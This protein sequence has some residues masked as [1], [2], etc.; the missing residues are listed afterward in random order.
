M[1]E[2][3][4]VQHNVR[5]EM[6]RAINEGGDLRSIRARVRQYLVPDKV[7]KEQPP[8]P[9]ERRFAKLAFDTLQSADRTINN[10]YA[11]ALDL[12]AATWT[13]GLIETSRC[14]CQKLNGKTWTREELEAIDKTDWDGKSGSIFITAGGHQCRHI[15]RWLGVAATLRKRPDL[16]LTDRKLTQRIGVEPQAFNKC[17]PKEKAKAT[18]NR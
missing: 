15:P 13:G 10:E 18:R 6:M 8:G 2:D 9:V 17:K 16:E 12:V 5:R 11:I 7:G 3:L 14:L 4:D 1:I